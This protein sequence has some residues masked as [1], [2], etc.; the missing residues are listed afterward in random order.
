VEAGKETGKETILEI[1]EGSRRGRRTTGGSLVTIETGSDFQIG[2]IADRL[3]KTKPFT[4]SPA[5]AN[6][7]Q[8]DAPSI[9]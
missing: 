1:Q 9:A 4:V 6:A 3:G 5:A 7:A 8:Y 2:P